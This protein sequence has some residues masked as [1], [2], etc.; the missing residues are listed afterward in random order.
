MREQP[1]RERGGKGTAAV[2]CSG[3]LGSES[4]ATSEQKTSQAG[5]DGSD[6]DRKSILHEDTPFRIESA[7]PRCPLM[8]RS[9]RSARVV[10]RQRAVPLPSLSH[11][12]CQDAA[13]A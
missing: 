8:T 2:L 11:I 13:I 4:G 10:H 3:L 7:V 1:R 12:D 5:E 9:L 6:A